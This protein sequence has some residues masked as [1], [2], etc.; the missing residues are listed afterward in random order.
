MKNQSLGLGVLFLLTLFHSLGAQ[1]LSIV[2]R[3]GPDGLPF[4]HDD[5]LRLGGY[6]SQN[7]FSAMAADACAE[8]VVHPHPT[9]GGVQADPKINSHPSR[10]GVADFVANGAGPTL[11]LE[12]PFDLTMWVSG[13]NLEDGRVGR[14]RAFPEGE[15]LSQIEEAALERGWVTGWQDTWAEADMDALMKGTADFEAGAGDRDMN[16]VH[17]PGSPIKDL[18]LETLGLSYRDI[19]NQ[20]GFPIA[21]K[22]ETLMKFEKFWNRVKDEIDEFH[23]FSQ[24]AYV[25]SWVSELTNLNTFDA[26]VSGNFVVDMAGLQMYQQ[27]SFE[28]E[29]GGCTATVDQLPLELGGPV[30]IINWTTY[31]KDT[32]IQDYFA[33]QR[34]DYVWKHTDLDGL[35]GICDGVKGLIKGL[36]EDKLKK[37]LEPMDIAASLMDKSSL[38]S[39][40]MTLFEAIAVYSGLANRGAKNVFDRLSLSVLTFFAQFKPT[41]WSPWAHLPGDQ[42]MMGFKSPKDL[43]SSQDVLNSQTGWRYNGGGTYIGKSMWLYGNSRSKDESEIR[44]SA[45]VNNGVKHLLAANKSTHLDRVDEAPDILWSYAMEWL[46]VRNDFIDPYEE[47][48]G[49]FVAN[50]YER[51]ALIERPDTTVAPIPIDWPPPNYGFGRAQVGTFRAASGG[52]PV[53]EDST[54]PGAPRKIANVSKG[55]F[56]LWSGMISIDPVSR[57]YSL[58]GAMKVANT[59]GVFDF[60][61]T[62]YDKRIGTTSKFTWSEPR[63]F[64]AGGTHVELPSYLEN[65]SGIRWLTG[66]VLSHYEKKAEFRWGWDFDSSQAGDL[67]SG[68][69]QQMG[70]VGTAEFGA[71]FAVQTKAEGGNKGRTGFSQVAMQAPLNVDQSSPLNPD[72]TNR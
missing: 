27:V 16:P 7:R 46:Y 63:G 53:L 37:K 43:T 34:F 35:W 52:D 60:S 45:D 47:E 24:Q 23:M 58:L 15:W 21:V 38:D 49:S 26:G 69:L 8:E 4:T 19:K 66:G 1:E 29:E 5:P 57:T 51:D 32:G 44:N 6:A 33:E 71:L 17:A 9:G 67:D 40:K 28:K 70:D 61:G 36:A 3:F 30:N 31:D 54:T 39:G 13:T 2:E 48:G 65:T 72:L 18:H 14:Y 25:E 41:E 10:P 42:A 50:W 12:A 20:F 22:Q 11:T 59:G 55:T 62:Y 68:H 56:Q 64:G